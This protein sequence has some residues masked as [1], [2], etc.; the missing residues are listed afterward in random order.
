MGLFDFGDREAVKTASIRLSAILSQTLV[1][2]QRE[3]S[4]ISL[5]S[6]AYAT[7]SKIKEFKALANKLSYDSLCSLKVYNNENKMPFWDFVKRINE[8]A[9]IVKDKTGIDIS[10]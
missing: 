6:M 3:N 2:L 7:D 1:E 4:N 10:Y 5:K 8:V 9:A